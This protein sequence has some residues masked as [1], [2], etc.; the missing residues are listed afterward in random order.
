[1]PQK[2]LSDSWAVFIILAMPTC[3]NIDGRVKK[4]GSSSVEE[5]K[6]RMRATE[7]TER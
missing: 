1:M 2:P 5:D 7:P 4:K 3:L 6:T